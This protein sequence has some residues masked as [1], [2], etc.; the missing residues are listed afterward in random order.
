MF[1]TGV[2]GFTPRPIVTAWQSLAQTIAASTFTKV[3]YQSVIYDPLAAFSDSRFVAPVAGIYMI[4]AALHT[5]SAAAGTRAV[6]SGFKNG[7]GPAV[8]FAN[9]RRMIDHG[10]SAAA[11]TRAVISGFKNGGG[12]AVTFANERRMI[13]GYSGAAGNIGVSGS[14]AFELVAGDYLEVF[15]YLSAALGTVARADVTAMSV[16][17]I[18]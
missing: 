3:L 2:V 17:R 16:F 6:I 7:G 13:D 18:G 12:P 15:A 1:P 9:E 8:T 4:T 10:G 5:E 14:C 11:G